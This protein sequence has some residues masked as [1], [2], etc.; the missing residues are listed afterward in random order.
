MERGSGPPLVLIPGIQGRWEWMMPTIDALA[1]THRV[2]SFSLMDI[3][4]G[5]A[6]QAWMAA[7]DRLLDRI[8]EPR[9]TLVG[10]SFGGL[11]AARYAA[12]RPERV[13]A[14][15]LVSSPAPGWRLDPE[16]ATYAR[17]PR[18]T[19]PFFAWRAIRRL[20]PEV[21]ASFPTWRGRVQFAAA[22]AIRALRWPVSPRQ[23]AAWVF[24]W[25]ATDIAA[26]CARITAPTLI[27]TGDSRLDRVVPVSSSLEYLTLIPGA[28]H[29]TLP[30]TGHVGL[31]A[32][33]REFAALV[34]RFLGAAPS[35]DPDP[36]ARQPP[37][38]ARAI[39][40]G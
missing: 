7:I 27:V 39:E 30:G 22:Y 36:R 12:H 28:R 17:R 4:G 20:T 14:L 3:S 37:I 18:A 8:G 1:R 31:L 35:E 5:S 32:K 11:V 34:D 29:A 13:A 40:C 10:A 16:S 19:L 38:R 26:D 21:I 15:V 24:E 6:F 9:A 25:M 23:M 33:P 2:L